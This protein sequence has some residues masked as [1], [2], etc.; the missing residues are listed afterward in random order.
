MIEIFL[1]TSWSGIKLIIIIDPISGTAMKF[2]KKSV[3]PSLVFCI[4][5]I[6][7]FAQGQQIGALRP[8]DDNHALATDS[9]DWKMHRI[10]KE[11]PL[12]KRNP[13]ILLSFGGEI[14]EQVKYSDH[15]NFGDVPSGYSDQDLYLQ[16]RYMLHANLQATRF[17]R[18]FIQLNSCHATGKDI[19]LPQ[20][21]RDD[22]GI[23]Q[24]FAD[25]YLNNS[26]TLRLRLGR[27]EFLYGLD[28]ILGLRDGPTVRQTF[29]GAKLTLATK[30]VTGDLFMVIPVSYEPGVFDN[31]RRSHEYVLGSYWMLPLKKNNTLDLY[32]FGVQ[33]PNANYANVIATDNRHSIGLR[34]G[35]SAGS[36]TYD[37][38][39]TY[40]FGQFGQQDIRAWHLSSQVYFRWQEY[41]WRPRLGIRES[42]YSGD[43]KQSDGIMNTFRPVSTKSP[44]HEMS[45]VGSA[46]L[47]L[48]SPEAEISLSGKLA[49]TLRYLAFWR[50]SGNDGIYPPDVR[51]MLRETDEPGKELGKAISQGPALELMYTPNKH[52]VVWIYY[53]YLIAGEYIHNTGAGNNMQAFS[54][55]AAYKF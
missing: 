6:S 13:V 39:F 5:S 49:F 38:E 14:R 18:L 11:I 3:Y 40:Q 8:L 52:V 7:A 51:R 41:R 24:A 36:F 2:M 15:L 44:V 23:M 45:S 55:R 46:N 33:F 37:A 27:Q 48:I 35:R 34:L 28:R 9:G 26:A 30:K 20:T 50:L 54:F 22:L 53:G 25:L 43:R 31:S 42:L 47:A 12:Q 21:D 4:L 10:I 1:L 19:M 32:Y 16:Q 17:L 29:D